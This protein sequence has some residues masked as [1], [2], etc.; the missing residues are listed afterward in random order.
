M[1]KYKYSYCETKRQREHAIDRALER[2]H[3]LLDKH[4]IKEIVRIIERGDANFI[5]HTTNNLKVYELQYYKWV[6]VVYSKI[7]HNIITFL[8]IKKKNSYNNKAR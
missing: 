4:D 1:V 7:N 6:R 8:P 2:Y 5:R 3:I